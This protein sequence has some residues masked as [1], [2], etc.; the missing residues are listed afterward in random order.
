VRPNK[1]ST[2][3]TGYQVSRSGDT[4]SCAHAM[5]PTD[6]SLTYTFQ[7]NS[8]RVKLTLNR[9]KLLFLYYFTVQQEKYA[10]FPEWLDPDQKGESR[11]TAM[12]LTF[13]FGIDAAGGKMQILPY[14]RNLIGFPS[15]QFTASKI[16]NV[17]ETYATI[18]VMEIVGW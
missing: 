18:E 8:T 17:T 9:M 2:E 7:S 11:W 13:E 15:Y 10:K 12:N 4:G 3:V 16:E 14:Q 6:G 5:H 1:T